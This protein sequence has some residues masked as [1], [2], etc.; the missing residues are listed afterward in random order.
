MVEDLKIRGFAARTQV[1]YLQCIEHYAEF[2]GKTPDE[3]G[4][5]DARTFLVYLVSEAEVSLGLLRHYV[6]A[7]RFLYRVT[8]GL[9]LSVDQIPYPRRE[10]RLPWIPSR[11][12]ILRFLA[13]VSNIKHRAAL[14]TCY[15]AGLRLSE[16]VALRLTDIDSR[17]MI[18][19][20]RQGK[21]RKDRMV[22]LSRTLLMV[23]R[24]YWKEVQPKEWLFPGRYGRHLSPRVIDFAC[25]RARRAAGIT[26][27]LTVH[28]LRHAFATHLFDAGT[29]LRTLQ[30]LLG[31]AS[32]RTTV[33][34]T[35]VSTREIQG[36]ISPLDLPD[37]TT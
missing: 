24:L 9:P 5:E 3:L 4:P 17:R 8:L 25:L 1:H 21:Y 11:E 30:M 28:T 13:A 29:N 20:V 12:E 2:F 7:L 6:S 37:P 22:P 31:H 36:V 33:V 18:L 34:Y 27:P 35:H 32:I 14:M 23:L 15:A 26:Q 10:H 19:F 16:V